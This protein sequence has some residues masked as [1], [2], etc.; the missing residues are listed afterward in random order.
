M[1]GTWAGAMLDLLIEEKAMGEIDF[2]AAWRRA[3]NR[4]QAKG[5]SRPRDFAHVAR[6]DDPGWLPYSAFVRRAYEREWYGQVRSDYIHLRD[7]LVEEPH[8]AS[9]RRG[10]HLTSHTVLLG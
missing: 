8:D 5:I 3:S 6:D 4:A 9:A 7:L 1:S 2:A 10:R